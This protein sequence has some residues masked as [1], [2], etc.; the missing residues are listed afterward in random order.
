MDH[1]SITGF[2]Q[3]IVDRKSSLLGYSQYLAYVQSRYN[4]YPDAT[5]RIEHLNR[6]YNTITREFFSTIRLTALNNL[7]GKYR[8]CFIILEND[9]VSPQ[10][11]GSVCGNPGWQ[12]DYV[13]KWIVRDMMNGSL[14][15]AVNSNGIWNENQSYTFTFSTLIQLNW[16]SQNCKIVTFVYKEGTPLNSSAEIQQADEESI[17]APL[18]VNPLGNEIPERYLLSQNF[19]NPFNPSTRIR[20][21]IPELKFTK[22]DVYNAIGE[23]IENLIS[24]DL[25]PG[26]YEVGFNS[27]NLPSGMYFYKIAAGDFIQTQQMVLVK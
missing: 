27:K 5:V 24:E 22:L 14:G 20:F 9:V 11:V 12:N 8:V 26:I 23:H 13:H 17:T 15:E 16:V 21:E 19:P 10:W 1:M 2:P 6:S 4:L 7:D 25:K 18:K 3:G